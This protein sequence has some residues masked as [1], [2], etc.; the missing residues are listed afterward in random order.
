VFIGI[1]HLDQGQYCE[2]YHVGVSRFTCI[3]RNLEVERS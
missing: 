1:S 2:G 3:I